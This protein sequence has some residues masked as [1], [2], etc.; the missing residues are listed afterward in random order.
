MPE[1]EVSPAEELEQLS[2]SASAFREEST[3]RQ[4]F[5]EA[6]DRFLRHIGLDR[7]GVIPRLDERIVRGRPDARIGGLIFEVKLPEPQGEGVGVAIE[8]VKRYIMEYK[9]RGELVRGV[10]YDGYNI[11]F[12]D[13]NCRMI[14]RGKAG[15]EAA[16]LESW[17]M[18][19]GGRAITPEDAIDRLGM[20]SPIA[21]DF[22]KSLWEV[23]RSSRQKIG[24]INKAY[25]IWE[26]LYGCATNLNADAV[27]GVKRTARSLDISLRSNTQV[28]HFLFALETYLAI[29]LKLLVARVTVQQRLVPYTSTLSLLQP[30]LS[31]RFAELEVLVPHLASVFEHDSFSWFY[32]ATRVDRD[33]ESRLDA[34]L[35]RTVEA[36]DDV[37]LTGLSRDFLRVFYQRFFDKSTRRALGEFYTSSRLMNETL[38]A[39]GYDGSL[40]KVIADISCGSGTFVIGAIRRAITKNIDLTPH[41][42]LQGI[43]DKIIGFDIHPLAVAMARVNYILA[44][45]ELLSP[46][47]LQLL[48]SI[49]IPIFWAD[50][51]V[52][53]TPEHE[54]GDLAALGVTKEIHI[55]GLGGFRLPDPRDLSW[56]KLFGTV[57]RLLGFQTGRVNLDE[58]WSRFKQEFAESEILRFENTLKDFVVN[59]VERHNDQ[60]DMRWLPLLNN[61]LAMEQ[62]VAQCDYIVGNPPW[63]RIHNIEKGFRD[64]LFSDYQF[65]RDSGWKL[66]CE[67]AGIGRGFGRQAD[68]SMAFVERGLELLKEGGTLAFVITA[69]IQQALYANVLRS[70][71]VLQT[72]I[73]KLIDYSLYAQP[74]FEDATN[75][76]LIIALDKREASTEHEL[77]VTIYNI[78]GNKIDYSASQKE[79]SLLREDTESPWIMAP[80]N[81]TKALRKMQNRNIVLLGMKKN[82]RPRIGIL[83]GSNRVFTGISAFAL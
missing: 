46:Q 70:H 27:N 75:Y 8:Q 18:V 73:R 21:R 66:G 36:V 54:T 81:V 10:A 20:P 22:I 38:D 57:R 64:R 25:R 53:L 42:I 23:F 33:T 50:S 34:L 31:A 62:I 16:T 74:L 26:G 79:L 2:T 12:I 32:D 47:T 19:L 82:I 63:V 77:D 60:R 67:L 17:L 6:L 29:L 4:Q 45:S 39:A 78:H 35:A 71:L 56:E 83:T 59:I 72:E 61:V 68:L 65:Y 13:E 7:R 52:R 40:D 58:F 49:R 37:D 69:K 5:V 51:L 14:Q 11:A 80:P 48:P 43:T 76:P 1:N 30:G 55:P 9:E 24:F 15:Q 44:I 3:L 28:K 41:E